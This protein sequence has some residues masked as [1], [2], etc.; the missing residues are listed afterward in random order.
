MAERDYGEFEW[1][2][3]NLVY[4]EQTHSLVHR[5][6]NHIKENGLPDSYKELQY[7]AND[8]IEE[9]WRDLDVNNKT[10]RD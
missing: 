9:I 3:R 10:D 2:I 4:C 6:Y 7:K 5:L 8:I 1:L